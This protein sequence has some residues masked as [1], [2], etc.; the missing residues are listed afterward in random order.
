MS[1]ENLNVQNELDEAN[2]VDDGRSPVQ[3]DQQIHAGKII[4]NKTGREVYFDGPDMVD[5]KTNKTITHGAL[6]KYPIHTLVK[7]ASEF[8]EV[9]EDV[10]MTQNGS[11]IDANPTNVSRSDLMRTMVQYATMMAPME[12]AAFVATLANPEEM[13]HSPEE[14]FDNNTS[15]ANGD[16]N[17]NKASIQSASAPAEAMKQIAKEDLELVFGDSQ[18]LSEEFKDKI[19]TIFEA[20][21]GT[22]VALEVAKIEE[23]LAEEA[24][25]ALDSIKE[26]MEENIDSY[27]NYAVAEWIEQNK[28]AVEENIK[29]EVTES[30]LAGLYNLFNE[31]HLD[32]PDDEVSV[33]E[34][35]L[36]MVEALESQIN[37]TTEKNIELTKVVSEKKVKE[38]AD[39]LSEGMTDTQKE[40]FT[41]LIEAVDYSSAEEFVK[42]ANII[43]ETYFAGKSE[44]KV[45]QDQLLSESVEEPEAAQ[46]VAP[47]MQAYVKSL[48]NTVKK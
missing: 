5:H 9:K 25:E 14:V 1:N 42:K 45:T 7:H 43:K 17:K 29:T 21:V 40:K 15:Y 16:A 28:L 41:K 23:E 2:V 39:E 38:A 20:A 4:R 27:L 34:S 44:V 13:T 35:L 10:A 6:G 11:T 3:Y 36:A 12:L 24:Q 33:V 22:R 19:G 48:S 31:H 8:K 30:F 26:E 18:D 32:I 37:E 46:Y 47:D